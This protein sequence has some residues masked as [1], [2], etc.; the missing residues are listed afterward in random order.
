MAWETNG[1]VVGLILALHGGQKDL[2]YQPTLLAWIGHA[3]GAM[4]EFFRQW[5]TTCLVRQRDGLLLAK[6]GTQIENRGPGALI[7]SES[8]RLQF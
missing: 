8:T 2:T 4:G 7:R 3:G 5:A 6:Y 1:L